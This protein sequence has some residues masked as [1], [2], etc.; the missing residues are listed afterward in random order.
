VFLLENKIEGVGWEADLQVKLLIAAGAVIPALAL[1]EWEYQGLGTIFV[2]P[3]AFDAD[4]RYGKGA[5]MAGQVTRAHSFNAMA[6]SRRHVLNSF[7]LPPDGRNVVVHEFAHLL[8]GAD[9]AIDGLMEINWTK[10]DRERWKNLTPHE[11]ERIR[12]GRT[13]IDRYALS[14]RVEFFAV[15][16]EYFFELPD[17][18]ACEHPEIYELL[19][20]GFQQDPRQLL[21]STGRQ[22]RYLELA[23]F[24]DQYW[25]QYDQQALA[26]EAF[27]RPPEQV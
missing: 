5:P 9:G 27:T 8:D 15:L 4:Y 10:E 11:Q 21:A 23:S 6:F 12:A 20:R 25:E 14:S 7:L 2:Y 24:R 1:Q 18:L 13:L 3:E 26:S 17:A 22:A 19:C 16:S